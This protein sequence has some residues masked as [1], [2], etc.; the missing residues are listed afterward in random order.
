M[1]FRLVIP[2]LVALL[3]IPR[4]LLR[5]SGHLLQEKALAV[6][7]KSIKCQP[8]FLLFVSDRGKPWTATFQG[9]IGL[10]RGFC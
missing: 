9:I 7:W 2:W 1:S 8:V 4:L 3:Q 10:F 6:R 5:Q